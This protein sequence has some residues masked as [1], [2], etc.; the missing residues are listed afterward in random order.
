MSTTPNPL[1]GA[2]S[3]AMVKLR[4]DDDM[5]ALMEAHASL[6]P[7]AIEKLDYEAARR[8]PTIADAMRV[9]LEAQGRSS[10][11]ES[12]VHG[13]RSRDITIDG[14]EGLLHARI[15]TPPGTAPFPVVVYF[16]GGGWV[17]ANKDV[18]DAGA[19]GLCKQSG[20]IVI[21]V[22]YRRAPEHRF[23]AAWNDALAAYKWTLANGATL[24]GDPE[25]VA[26]AGESAGGN[27]ALA[28]AIAARNSQL[29]PP[30]HVLAV[31]PVT[32]TSLNTEAYLENA[33]AKPLNRSMMQWFFEH[34]VEDAQDLE[35]PRLQLIDAELEGLPP[36]TLIT[37][38][39]DPLRGDGVKMQ[40]ALESAGVEV[41]RRDYAGVTHEFFG[42]A[43]VLE[44]AR[45]AQ[46]FAGQQLRQAFGTA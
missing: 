6:N 43:A 19:R 1:I 34:V 11:P 24:G 39:I 20:A 29:V 30:V 28:T 18:Y 33:I 9:M 44:K 23:P 45:E 3:K 5:L 40:S 14:A 4:A 26:L 15:Y 2:I 27:L 13:V 25:R 46:K 12:L 16:H 17:L 35:D 7:L 31:Y 8:N 32:Q 41:V 36:V 10:D 42:A 21:S 38:H 37:A 22:D